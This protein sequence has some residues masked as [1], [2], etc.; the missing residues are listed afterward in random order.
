[1]FPASLIVN[2]RAGCCDGAAGLLADCGAVSEFC[3]GL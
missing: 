1:M 3:S 2:H